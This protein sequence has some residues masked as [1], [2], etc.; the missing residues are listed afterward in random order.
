MASE[1]LVVNA[2]PLVFLG[3]AGHLELLRAIGASRVMVPQ[4]VFDEVTDA[5]HPDAA[6]H[7][8]SAAGWIERVPPSAIPASVSAWDLGPGESSVIA[9]A[10]GHPGARVVIDDLSGR[11]CA[12]AHGVE[13]IGSLGVVI[14][15]HR[16]GV[17]VDSRAVMLDLR[18][19]G[20]WLSDAILERAL[21][22]AG[23]ES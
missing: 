13:V 7:I 19:R 17:V 18:A 16:R 6:A 9:V 12:L 8:V 23:V 20:M 14:G 22:L 2:S 4:A 10:L 15:A 5:A 1:F 11:R 3:N 21:R